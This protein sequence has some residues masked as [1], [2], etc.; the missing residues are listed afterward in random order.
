MLSRKAFDIAEEFREEMDS[1]EIS[2]LEE[3]STVLICSYEKGPIT[4]EYTPVI[5][6]KDKS[7]INKL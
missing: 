5:R 3:S 6:V 2:P 1:G 4:K 7:S